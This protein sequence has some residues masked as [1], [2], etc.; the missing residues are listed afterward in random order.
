M[1]S[2]NRTPKSVLVTG[3]DGALG[4][5]VAGKFRDSGCRVLAT[6]HA[7]AGKPK[8]EANGLEWIGVDLSDA[9]SIRAAKLADAGIDALL[10]CAGGF[11]F[12]QV[13]QASDEDLQFLIDANL[14]SAI[15][16]ARELVGPMKKRGFGRIVFV[17][18]R[19]TFQ[20]PAGMGAYAATKAGLNALTESLAEET[21][22]FDINVNSVLPTVI[23]TPAN[24]R[25]MPKADFST[26]VSPDQLAEIIFSLT[27]PWG[28]P[29]HGALIPVAGRV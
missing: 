6:Y 10:H 18:S 3:A 9:S 15:L 24:R 26:W 2:P 13:E 17:S 19:A 20:P 22:A 25:D 28:K 21:K 23:D 8:P 4:S 7:R 1:T 11:R 29:I 14:K 12:G 27:Q 16:L 5:V